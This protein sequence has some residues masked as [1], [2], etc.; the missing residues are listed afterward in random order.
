LFDSR[1]QH[2]VP[3]QAERTATT[4]AKLLDA[5]ASCLAELGYHRTSTTEI[6][7]RAG[8]SRGA[9]LHHFPTKADLLAAAFDHVWDRRAQEFRTLVQTLPTGPERIDGAVDVLWSVF[10]G[11]TFAAWFE[12]AAAARTDPELQALLS[13]RA[14]AMG[15][16][17]RDLWVE[18]FPPPPGHRPTPVYYDTAPLFFFTVLDGLAVRRLTNTQMVDDEAA[19]VLNAVKVLAADNPLYE[20]EDAT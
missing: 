20:P 5:A 15:E 9:Q 19:I 16:R 11:D 8:V 6:C 3:T 4:Q 1:Y 17:I 2:L 7:R 13:Q 10:Q 18:L 12:L 14:H